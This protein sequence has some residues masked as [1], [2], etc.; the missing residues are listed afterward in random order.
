[1]GQYFLGVV[2]RDASKDAFMEGEIAT[3]SPYDGDAGGKLVEH[4]YNGMRTISAVE[5]DLFERPARVVWAG[6]YADDE[7]GVAVSEDSPYQNLYHLLRGENTLRQV[8]P[9]DVAEQPTFL[10]NAERRVA[11]VNAD[12]PHSVRRRNSPRRQF[13]WL[14]LLTAEGNGRGG[15]DY[16]QSPNGFVGSWARE[17]VYT[18]NTLP[19]G[20]TVINPRAES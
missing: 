10:V 14:A 20:V 16:E 12:S 7:P 17:L 3:F 15:G 11:V 19:L 18:T 6:D 9:V 1:M 5:Q 2:S 8:I 4:A 13:S